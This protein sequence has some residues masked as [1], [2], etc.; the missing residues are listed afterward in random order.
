MKAVW[1]IVALWSVIFL[2]AVLSHCWMIWSDT[3]VKP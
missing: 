2:C 1:L 3:Q